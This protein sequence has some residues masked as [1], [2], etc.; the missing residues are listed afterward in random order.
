MSM[1]GGFATVSYVGSGSLL[2]IPQVIVPALRGG[3]ICCRQ[4]ASGWGIVS[5]IGPISR[6]ISYSVPSFIENTSTQ[7]YVLQ[8]ATLETSSPLGIKEAFL[9]LYTRQGDHQWNRLRIGFSGPLQPAEDFLVSN[10]AVIQTSGALEVVCPTA[11]GRL[12]HWTSLDLLGTEWSENSQFGSVGNNP[13][14]IALLQD[15][16][17]PYSFLVIAAYSDRLDLYVHGSRWG[18]LTGWSDGRTIWTPPAGLT[19]VGVP[20]FYQE[21]VLHFS[22]WPFPRRVWSG[23]DF[24]AAVALSDGR[25]HTVQILR[26]DRNALTT[27]TCR[28]EGAAIQPLVPAEPGTPEVGAVA[29]V[30]HPPSRGPFPFPILSWFSVLKRDLYLWWG[31]FTQRYTQ[32]DTNWQFLEGVPTAQVPFSPPP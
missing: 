4:D 8:M 28:T 11:S 10:P 13:P 31:N 29:L 24:L 27:A 16:E 2:A 26:L 12:R 14:S 30:Q 9:W 23:G 19:L 18:G 5:I 3:L 22:L 21:P 17:S 6:E 15:A 7:P 1:G 25:M 32:S 20:A